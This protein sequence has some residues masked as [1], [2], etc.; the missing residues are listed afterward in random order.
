[1]AAP[2]NSTRV[3]GP[4]AIV[5]DGSPV[6]VTGTCREKSSRIVG[7]VTSNLSYSAHEDLPESL[8]D[9]ASPSVPVTP[10][11]GTVRRVLS[12]SR[13]LVAWDGLAFEGERTASGLAVGD[14]VSARGSAPLVRC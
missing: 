13:V 1:V 3:P 9:L 2:S 5:A 4:S 14:R 12:P 8:S 7:K 6:I 11:L 10:R